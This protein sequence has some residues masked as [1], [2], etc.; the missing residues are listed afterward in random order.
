MQR[1][2]LEYY[3]QL[4]TA[5]LR[6]GD[7]P[8]DAADRHK[9][10]APQEHHRTIDQALTNVLTRARR[11][12]TL[13]EPRAF[14]KPHDD[15]PWYTGPAEDDVTWPAYRAHLESR[16]PDHAVS[17][18]DGSTS[19]I[20]ALMQ[21]PGLGE[22]STRGLV[23]GHVQS[24]KTANYI[25]LIAKAADV[26]YRLFVVLTGM[27]EALRV[28]T[29]ERVERDLIELRRDRWVQL[30]SRQSDFRE[31]TNVNVFLAEHARLHSIAIVKKN[32]PVLRRLIRW[33]GGARDEIKRNCPVVIIDDEADQASINTA[34][35]DERTA[36]N[37]CILDIL[38]SLPKAAYIGYTATPFANVLIDP[39]VDQDLYPRDFIVDL[40]QPRDHFGPEKI[41]GREQL[42]LDDPDAE[43]DGLDMIRIVP[44][45]ETEG[46]R[47]SRMEEFQPSLP[48]SLRTAC[49]YF[50][51]ATAARR[52]RG[53]RDEHSTMLV[54]TTVRVAAHNAIQPL[55]N[56]LRSEVHGALVSQDESLTQ[57]MR[58]IWIHEQARV[59]PQGPDELPLAFE[60][61][62][63]LLPDVVHD[64]RVLVENASSP[65]RVDYSEP[66]QSV[67]VIG[68]SILSRGL[69]LEG[70]VVSY[71]IRTSSAYD[72]L[73]QMGRWFG[74]RHGYS[75]L[76]RIWMTAELCKY[77]YDLATVEREIR[78][79]VERYENENLSPSDFAVRIRT[80]PALNITSP[81][82]MAAAVE[83][84]RSFNGRRVQTILFKHRSQDWLLRNLQSTRKLIAT[85]RDANVTPVRLQA[86]AGW[87]L[88]RIDHEHVLQFLDEYQF[89]EN[90]RELSSGLIRGYITDQVHQAGQL[91]DWNLV[92][93]SRAPADARLGVID[94][95]FDEDVALIN[96]SRMPPNPG[97]P[98]D[99]ADIKALMSLPDVV[100]DIPDLRK[101][102]AGRSMDQLIGD[103]SQILPGVGCLLVYPISRHSIPARERSDRRRLESVEDMIGVGL[104]FPRSPVETDQTYVSAKLPD[105]V[106]EEVLEL[107]P[108]EAA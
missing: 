19:K 90:S 24:G 69:T 64:S 54:H 102:A 82:K 26:G 46:L 100:A 42:D 17:S 60:D 79:D 40:P 11:I 97:F 80:H 55:V 31:H 75:D 33:L 87:L 2:H 38:G 49:L 98:V 21:P 99:S 39:S 71:F 104:V 61:V 108:E 10:F 27:V 3:E 50:W 77:F 48:P 92:V 70:L 47:P 63:P 103:R 59:P 53:Q 8:G 81:G 43:L 6:R 72:T 89:H 9:S 88:E 78:Y 25:G 32:G 5:D 18:I 41:F 28:Q 73:L 15:E 4:L 14:Q 85:A 23:L 68:G 51:M 62:S 107:P 44:D 20:L 91:A 37:A 56:S 12:G 52:A 94:L 7:R 34:G 65:E 106:D 58:S 105:E 16:L 22:I 101:G 36:I 13:R 74:Y 35:G 96:R 83:V 84:K 29:Q 86:G 30:T 76:P 1:S 45:D 95:G 66:G 67:I 93:V 57:E